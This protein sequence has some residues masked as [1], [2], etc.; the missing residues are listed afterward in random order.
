MILVVDPA[1]TTLLDFRYKTHYR[2]NRG[3]HGQGSKKDGKN[4]E[5][6]VIRVPP[7]TVIREDETGNVLAD[8]IYPEQ[9]LLARGEEGRSRQCGI[10][11]LDQAGPYLCGKRRTG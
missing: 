1:M 2:A 4:A 7:G 6:L 9:K 10:C 3:I 5:D 11:H 8:L